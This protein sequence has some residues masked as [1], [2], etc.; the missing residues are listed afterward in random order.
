MLSK[1]EIRIGGH[2]VVEHSPTVDEA[3]GSTLSTTKRKV[4]LY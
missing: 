1:V 3:L 2:S 4:D